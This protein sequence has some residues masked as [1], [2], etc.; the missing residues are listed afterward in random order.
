MNNIVDLQYH[1]EVSEYDKIL[2]RI[3]ELLIV[4]GLS[5]AERNIYSVMR[6]VVYKNQHEHLYTTYAA[7]ATPAFLKVVEVLEN[8]IFDN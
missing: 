7:K 8:E 1:R 2:D 4:Y 3:K 6:M 5:S